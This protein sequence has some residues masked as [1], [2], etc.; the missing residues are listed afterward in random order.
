MSQVTVIYHS[1]TGT[2]K[3]LAEAAV[4]G[5]KEAGAEAVLVAASEAGVKDLADATAVLV[6]MPQ[7]FG[8][9][10]GEV[11]SMFERFYV[12]K[13]EI[14][15]ELPMAVIVN[16]FNDPDMTLGL[17]TGITGALG[18]VPFGEWLKLNAGELESNLSV[19]RE[20]GA[21]LANA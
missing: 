9:M 10:T 3:Q 5:A 11:K 20:L 4:E 15:G 14:K 19:A 7:S 2:T 6:A 13:D 1:F 18:F 16:H 8:T 21:A 12:Q 17:M